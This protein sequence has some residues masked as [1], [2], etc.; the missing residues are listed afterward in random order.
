MVNTIFDVSATFAFK[1]VSALRKSV[2]RSVGHV[3]YNLHFFSLFGRKLG[4]N[5]TIV[6]ITFTRKAVNKVSGA[7]I[8]RGVVHLFL[9]FYRLF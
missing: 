9:R 6:S 2:T 7:R 3:F 5:M 1:K 4:Y 8:V